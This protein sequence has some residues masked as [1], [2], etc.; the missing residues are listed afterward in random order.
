MPKGND[1]EETLRKSK[2]IK[3]EAVKTA[4]EDKGASVRCAR[5]QNTSADG[6]SLFVIP[7]TG[8]K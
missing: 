4:K 3:A 8:K 1:R 2:K 5:K 6:G 7:K